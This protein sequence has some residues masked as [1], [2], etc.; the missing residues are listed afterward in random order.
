L[1]LANNVATLLSVLEVTGFPSGDIEDISFGIVTTDNTVRMAFANR[2]AISATT[3]FHVYFARVGLDNATVVGT[4]I[5]LSSGDD[6]TITGSDGF[7][8][9]PSLRL[10]ALN[11]SHIAWAA[12]DS[13]RNSGGVYYALVKETNGIDNTAIGAT[14]VLGTTRDWGHPSVLVSATN[15]VVVL[16]ADEFIPGTAGAVGLVQ[17]NPDAVT[18]NG[19]PVSIGTVRTFLLLGPAILLE[20]FKLYRPEAFLDAKGRIHM[21]GYGTSGST[22]TYYSFKLIS[23]SP[24]AEFVTPPVPVGFNEFPAERAEDYTKAAFEFLNGKAMVFWS[25]LI[26][27]SSANRNLNVTTV[28]AVVD[29]TPTQ[30]SGCSMVADPRAGERGRIPGTALLFLPAVI[31]AVRRVLARISHQLPTAA[32]DTGMSTAL[33]S[34]VL[35]DVVSTTPAVP[36]HRA[37]CIHARLRRLATEPGEKCGLAGGRITHRRAVAK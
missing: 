24:F 22:S 13:T 16:A 36:E 2:S 29:V 5:L 4:P 34:F 15:S 1:A 11:R 28:P 3:P 6:N 12:N 20:P 30:E 14:E 35:L 23:V 33:H 8:P 32:A 25:G 26:P 17:V 27:G 31:L 19:L 18:H 21:T 9:V 37:P 10:D 7:R